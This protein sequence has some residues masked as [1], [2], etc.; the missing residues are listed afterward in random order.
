MRGVRE[1]ACGGSWANGV[2]KKYK[3]DT[4]T[5]TRQEHGHEPRALFHSPVHCSLSFF[6]NRGRNRKT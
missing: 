6:C 1:I 2:T 3:K 5:H 4:N